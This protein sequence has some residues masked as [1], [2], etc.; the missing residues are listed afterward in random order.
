[1]RLWDTYLAAAAPLAGGGRRGMAW[2]RAADVR[3]AGSD[4]VH[5]YGTG[6]SNARGQ[7]KH[8]LPRRSSKHRLGRVSVRVLAKVLV[9]LCQR[10]DQ[11][12]V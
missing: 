3:I 2:R 6:V 5:T 9:R 11:T 12:A 8:C 10:T 4:Q 1:M 7:A